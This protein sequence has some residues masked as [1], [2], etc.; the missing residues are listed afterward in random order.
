[1]LVEAWRAVM[2][3]NTSLWWR[4]GEGKVKWHGCAD[5]PRLLDDKSGWIAFI[6]FQ[7]KVSP[8]GKKGWTPWSVLGL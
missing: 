5:S 1:M 2:R 7:E 3:E 4:N 8:S 6:H